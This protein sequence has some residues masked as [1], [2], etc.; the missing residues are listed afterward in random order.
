MHR[1]GL[2]AL[3]RNLAKEVSGE[4]EEHRKVAAV[5][6]HMVLEMGHR[7][8]AAEKDIGL[9]EERRIGLVEEHR[10]VLAGGLRMAAVDIAPEAGCI[11]AGDMDFEKGHHRLGEAGDSLEVA[12]QAAGSPVVGHI[13]EQAKNR[14]L[15]AAAVVDGNIGHVAAADN[16]LSNSQY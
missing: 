13:Q 6:L 2:V 16:L 15:V 10:I 14:N 1:T 4:P 7:I 3:S 9:V 8:V 12:G 11:A 5:R